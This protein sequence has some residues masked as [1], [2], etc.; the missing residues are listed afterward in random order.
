M[1]FLKCWV[2]MGIFITLSVLLGVL[3]GGALLLKAPSI[4]SPSVAYME[5]KIKSEYEDIV[6][7]ETESDSI[8]GIVSPP[9]KPLGINKKKDTLDMLYNDISSGIKFSNSSNNKEDK[10][11]KNKTSSKS[12]L[13]FLSFLYNFFS[14]GVGFLLF[15]LGVLVSLFVFLFKREKK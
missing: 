12:F 14:K 6:S 3:G 2:D 7:R 9:I 13:G 1:V 8:P 5:E 10:E 15:L 11:D 4:S